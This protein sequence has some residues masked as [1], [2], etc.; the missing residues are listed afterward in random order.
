MRPVTNFARPRYTRSRVNAAGRRFRHGTPTFDDRLVL[1]NWRLSH[2]YVLNTFQMNLRNR[3]RGMDAKVVQR[4]KRRATIFD[5]LHREPNMALSNMHDIA[6]CRVIFSSIDDLDAFR[7]GLHQSRAQHEVQENQEQYNYLMQPKTTGY[8]GV[9]D[10]YRY[11]VSSDAGSA[12][13]G[14]SVE[15]QY[16]TQVQHAWATAVE[17]A[18]LTTESRIKFAEGA[19]VQTEFFRLASELLARGMEG[20]PSCCAH[21]TNEE[22]VDEF[23]RLAHVS[24]LWASLSMLEAADAT[25]SVRQHAI[26][27]YHLGADVEAW[28]RLEV[29]R[30]DT[31]TKALQELQELE[32]TLG[33]TADVVLVRA[34]TE[35]SLR[36]A[37]SNY[38]SDVRAFLSY[39]KTS[40]HQIGTADQVD[41]IL[42]DLAV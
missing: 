39:V 38:Y 37:Y 7:E 27:I 18:D 10:V 42:S 6:G 4:H 41:R 11:K 13:N 22:V 12:W 1:E 29:R 26:L 19:A 33:D 24:G 5:K 3:A 2:A 20:M 36:E 9:H 14:L 40:I 21:L 15:V 30:F 8:R 34:D 16:R 17:V 32:T 28:Q 31:S 23:A 35:A 25:P